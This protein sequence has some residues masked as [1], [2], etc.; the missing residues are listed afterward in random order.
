LENQRNQKR[1]NN[2]NR[3]DTV[4]AKN[5]IKQQKTFTKQRKI[6]SDN[7]TQQILSDKFQSKA[8]EMLEEIIDNHKR[9]LEKDKNAHSKNI[10]V[11]TK[12][13]EKTLNEATKIKEECSAAEIAE[14]TQSKYKKME[15]K[16]LESKAR[17]HQKRINEVRHNKLKAQIENCQISLENRDGKMR[18]TIISKLE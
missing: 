1:A 13:F 14:N 3:I 6:I 15:E 17:R 7:K 10:E 12:I 16:K 8:R 18:K 11:I 2:Y 4:H 9:E 5:L